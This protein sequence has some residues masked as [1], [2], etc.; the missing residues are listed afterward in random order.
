MMGI[1]AFTVEG[2]NITAGVDVESYTLESGEV[3]RGIF[4]GRADKPGFLA[5]V[6]NRLRNQ[7][8]AQT[9]IKAVTMDLAAPRLVACSDT[10]EIDE[11]QALVVFRAVQSGNETCYRGD[12]KR[13]FEGGWSL[14]SEG[15][16]P[17]QFSDEVV[18]IGTAQFIQLLRKGDVF[19]AWVS[20][21]KGLH[22]ELYLWDGTHLLRQAKNT[23]RL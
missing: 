22:T 2:G 12:T 16:V 9:R 1:S 3:I 17:I 19:S 5:V 10:E 23:I 15:A 11:S 7:E 8:G 13:V 14:H 21:S 6:D 4:V 18:G 20:N